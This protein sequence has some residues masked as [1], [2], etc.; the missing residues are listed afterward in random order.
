MGT[1]FTPGLDAGH[2]RTGSRNPGD[3]NTGKSVAG[4]IDTQDAIARAAATG[5]SVREGGNLEGSGPLSSS[6]DSD[7]SYMAER[8]F[9]DYR[10]MTGRLPTYPMPTFINDPPQPHTGSRLPGLSSYW[11]VAERYDFERNVAHFSTDWAAIGRNMGTK[12]QA[13]VQNHYLLLVEGG[14]R[15]DLQQAAIE[16]DGR[17]ERGED[18]GPP[19]TPT[20][21]LRW[22]TQP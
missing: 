22:P 6:F 15:P 5:L 11:S 17:R 3:G 14:E 8:M 13:M 19:P 18:L 9:D 7:D 2:R 1:Y 12:S 20:P 16:A 4:N 10:R 21:R